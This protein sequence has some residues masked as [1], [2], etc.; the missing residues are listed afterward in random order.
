LAAAAAA[1]GARTGTRVVR[2]LQARRKCARMVEASARRTGFTWP[3]NVF[4]VV[5][6]VLF[7]FFIA[8]FY[9]LTFLYLNT[10]ERVAAG[11]L[12]G[13]AAVTTLV[14][15][16]VA[17]AVDPA[18]PAIYHTAPQDAVA[19]ST[20]GMLYCQ[21]CE[22]FVHESSKHCTVCSKCVHRF[23]HHCMWLNTCVG[24]ITYRCVLVAATAMH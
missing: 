12:F 8:F 2:P 19:C 13:V 20:A 15:A 3:S 14:A 22:S 10:D 21:R 5:S 4:Q 17:T 11:V 7:F 6:W 24:S 18:D 23:D 9:A 16:V 1:V